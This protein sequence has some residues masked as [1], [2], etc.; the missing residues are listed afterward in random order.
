MRCAAPIRLAV[1]L[2]IS[3]AAWNVAAEDNPAWSPLFNGKDLTGWKRFLEPGKGGD[4]DKVW[5]VANGEITCLGKPAGYIITEKEYDSFVLK[6]E[7]RWPSKP[8]NSGC[9]VYVVGEDKVWPKGVEAQLMHE[10]AGDFWLVDGFKLDIDNARKDPKSDRHWFRAKDNVEK[11]A[12]EWNQYE[13]YCQ[14]D[15]VRLVINGHDVNVGTK[16][17]LTR[18]KILLQSEGSEIQ[19]RNI[20]I[21]PLK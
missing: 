21:K 6:F 8:G 18:G 7:W 13:V 12:G 17:E 16:P 15:T 10:H 2:T 19:F 20:A 5:T 9:F 4:P 11:P 1:L 3:L 14:G